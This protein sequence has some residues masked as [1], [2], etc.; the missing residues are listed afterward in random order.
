MKVNEIRNLPK[1]IR[2]NITNKSYINKIHLF[3]IRDGKSE[4]KMAHDSYKRCRILE[5]E[6]WDK[7]LDLRKHF[8]DDEMLNLDIS[9]K[10]G[11]LSSNTI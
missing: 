10:L 6:L 8:I 11:R 5:S 3:L 4:F 1:E 2:N 9:S 7:Y